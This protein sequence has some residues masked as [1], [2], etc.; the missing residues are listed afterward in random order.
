ME[1]GEFPHL[2]LI[3]FAG[4]GEY[5]S[6]ARIRNSFTREEWWRLGGLGGAVVFLHLAGWGLV[7]YYSASHPVIAGLGTLAYTFGLRHA[8]DADHLA[9]IDNSTRKLLAEGQRPLGV[10]FFF[11]LGHSSVVFALATGLAVATQAV[12]AA[13][14]ALQSYGGYVGAGISGSFLLAIGILNVLVLRDILGIARGLRAGRFDE[15]ELERR[16]LDRGFMNRFFIG[17]LARL[18]RS[19]R[20]MYPLGV[21]FGLGFD[22]ASEI[23]LLALT[24][25][26]AG[27]HTPF[28]AII[29]LPL[30]FAAGMSLMDTA[31][32]IFMAK[33]YGWAFSSPA[34]KVF[35][36]ITITALSVTVALAVGA[37]ELVQLTG[38]PVGLDFE[39]LGYVIL[40]LFVLT[41]LVASLVWKLRR[42]EERWVLPSARAD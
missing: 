33:A 7:L 27:G 11:S 42:I 34:R 2:A 31:D 16:L 24:A 30:L 36:N 18:I 40:G 12:G 4:R 3:R 26:I 5:L 39:T 9:A 14:P 1:I 17:R 41:W 20:H 35:Y 23:G 22:T 25:G 32:G 38:A 21:L 29:A 28:L 15:D 6:M 19:S 13:V 37:V 8:F 10:G